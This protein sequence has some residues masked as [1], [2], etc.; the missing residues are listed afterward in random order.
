MCLN[1]DYA[2]SSVC[3]CMYTYI[4]CNSPQRPQEGRRLDH[5]VAVGL[6]GFRI[7]QLSP[8]LKDLVRRPWRHVIWLCESFLPGFAWV[9]TWG[10]LQLP[11]V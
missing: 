8:V 6:Q 9:S 7:N 2:R 4:A 5:R 3:V 11:G 10:I 1:D